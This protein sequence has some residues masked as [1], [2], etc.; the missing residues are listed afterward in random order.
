MPTLAERCENKIEL[1]E[2]LRRRITP[3][4]NQFSRFPSHRAWQNEKL[5]SWSPE[6][7]DAERRFRQPQAKLFPYIGRK[8]NTPGGPGT[9]I[10]VFAERVPCFSILG[11]PG[12][13]SLSPGKLSR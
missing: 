2:F 8:V 4:E 7:I 12:A 3:A 11:Y 6:S 13:R 9:L 5:E 1:L 10:Q